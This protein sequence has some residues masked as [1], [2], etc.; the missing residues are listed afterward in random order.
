LNVPAYAR[1]DYV[2]K[3]ASEFLAQYEINSFPIDPMLIIKQEQWGVQKYSDLMIAFNCSV[4]Q[5]CKCLRSL[6]GYTMY[7]ENNYTIAYNDVGKTVGR[8]RFTLMHEIGHIY[9]NHLVDFE[10]TCIQRGGLTKAEDQVLENEANAFARNVL[11]PTSMI[12]QLNNKNPS[13][14]AEIFGIT[15]KAA[16]VR[17]ELFQTDYSVN[18]NAGMLDQLNKIFYCYYYKKKC[19]I[20]NASIIQKHGRFCPICG[21]KTLKWGDGK[22]KYKKF[23]TNENKKL[24]ECPRCKNEETDIVGNYCQICRTYLVNKCSEIDCETPL[25]TNARYCPICGSESI[26]YRN[27]I[28]NAWNY[29]ELDGGFTDILDE[30]PSHGFMNNPNLFDD[31]KLPFN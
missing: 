17:L 9:L 22:V 7:D 20:C 1:Y 4:D 30:E 23:E 14:I 12:Q 10:K 16:R 5:V 11:V 31:E 19:S 21:N 13:K 15:Y 18:K 8:I 29:Q 28:L 27:K 26:F 24:K 25:E 6:D 3:K 2:N